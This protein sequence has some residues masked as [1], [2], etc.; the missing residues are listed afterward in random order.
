MLVQLQESNSEDVRHV[1]RHF[2]LSYNENSIPA[3][4]A[5]EAAGLQKKEAFYELKEDLFANQGEWSAL[6]QE[7]FVDYLIE[8]ADA[9]GLDTEQFA[10]DMQD[11]G[12]AQKINDM[13]ESGT[14][15]VSGTPYILLDGIPI[16]AYATND[17][18]EAV[19]A[20]RKMQEIQYDECPSMDIDLEK[21]YTA[22]LETNK[23]DI[24]IELYAEKA[25]ITVNSFVFLANEGWYDGVPFHRVVPGFVAQAG[26]PLGLGF[27]GPGYEFI[28]EIDPELKYSEPGYV[29]MANHG[30]NTN[31]SQFF[32]VLREVPEL[33]GSFTIF[34]KV[35]S[36]MDIVEELTPRNP[37][38]GGDLPD[39]DVI[40]KVTINE[41]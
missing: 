28:N 23:G 16:S 6:P 5:V 14:P 8:K 12:I 7:G 29:G 26:D 10:E 31:G 24:V 2:P 22:T 20:A 34:G 3:A 37:A 1:F 33:D 11:E 35:T 36:G 39:P 18:D 30:P 38:E 27:G 17:L 40:E 15:F 19:A 13:Y 9:L 4:M 32:I 41:R 25:P 21:D